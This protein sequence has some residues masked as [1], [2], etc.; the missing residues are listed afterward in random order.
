[1][2]EILCAGRTIPGVLYLQK[3]GLAAPTVVFIPG[4]DNTKENYPNP[5]KNEFHMRGMNVL[6]IDGPGQGEALDR[7]VYVNATNHVEAASSVL[8]F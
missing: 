8:I 2:V 6:A 3:D 4:M 1:L 7:G 5:L